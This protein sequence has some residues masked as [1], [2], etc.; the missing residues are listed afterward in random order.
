MKSRLFCNRSA[1]E[2]PTRTALARIL[3][4]IALVVPSSVAVAGDA[5]QWMH[6]VVNAP[7]PAHDEKTNAVLLYSETN[8]TVQSTDKIK[9]VV[10]RAYKILRPDGRDVGFAVVPFNSPSEK[11]NGLHGWC[12]PA[13]GKDYEVKDK[14]AI[15]RSL[16]KVDG[17]ELI[18]DVRVKVIEIPASDPGNI[19]GYEYTIEEQPVLLQE[20]W[21]F[22]GENPLREGHYSLQLPAGWEYKAA[23]LNHSEVKPTQTGSN[24]WQWT[25]T[26]EKGIREEQD[27]PPIHG[28]EG[29]MIV[30]LLP[31]GGVGSRGFANWKEMG[32][33][34]GNL[35]TGRR[36]ATPDIKQKVAELTA[37][38]TNPL[39]KM[40][41]IARFVQHDIRYVAIE[42]GIGGFQPHPAADVFGHR[43]GDCKDKATLM[44][45]MLHEIGVDSF[46]VVINSQRGSVT[47]DM[48]ANDGFNHVI[49][50]IKLP[51]GISEESLVAT[52]QHQQ[53]GKL[54]FFDP[55]NQLT[56]LG[57]IGGYLQENYG[58]LVTPVGGELVELPRLPV[59]MNT[60][61][62]TGNLTLDATG[63]LTGS[64]SEMRLGD[65]AS[66]ER[67]RLLHVTN[68]ADR[69]K[70][71]ETLL[72]GSLSNFR[73]LKASIVN[74]QQTDQP[75][76]FNYS[77][78]ALNYAKNAGDLLLLRPRVLG[79]KADAILE[80]PEPRLF[81]IEFD[82]PVQDTDTF[83]ITFPEG[84]TVDD[85]PP[86][87]DAD[88]G[89][90][91]YH[92]KTQVKGNVIGY[93][94][95]FEVKDLSVTVSKAA[96]LKKFYRII[97]GDERNTAVLKL[98]K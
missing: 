17:S 21:Y 66:S 85:L 67:W 36:D 56:P 6:A 23:Y 9:T 77:F 30:Y 2:R 34:Y 42:L 5:P 27:M 93:T 44:A 35:T 89:F 24:Q 61:R 16:P 95:T 87:V 25:V 84:Y 79:V 32:S 46:Y 3:L 52:M 22:Q 53:L 58:L 94:R 86:P 59:T 74:L 75:F 14:D 96:D 13:Q 80:T 92:S 18:S 81:P 19:V 31:P 82:G 57:Q 60:I 29:K 20:T 12:I 39:D 54:L 8:V 76:G 50:A 83:E 45:A 7:L 98:S 38:A 71:I 72:A 78:E 43:Y 91:S 51:S 40:R 64:V 65:R 1:R 4:G 49:L 97:A 28:V 55:T 47:A 48:P 41:A 33:W 62:R 90:A 26:D 11:V 10:R 73:I 15:E 88:F 68:N 69:I 63:K 70:P 37:G